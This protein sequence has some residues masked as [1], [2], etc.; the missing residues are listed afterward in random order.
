VGSGHI[1]E[2]EAAA[3][4]KQRLLAEIAKDK[5]ERRARC[6]IRPGAFVLGRG[7]SPSTTTITTLTIMRAMLAHCRH[8]CRL[9]CV[10]SVNLF[11][12][13]YR[14]AWCR[15]GLPPEPVK[16]VAASGVAAP[17]SNEAQLA[18]AIETLS[19][20]KVWSHVLAAVLVLP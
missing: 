3:K 9:D 18:K 7:P 12:L 19:Q 8:G 20:Y 2:K 4:E 5:A 10:F 17:L 16:P 14:D 15:M 11:C 13:L 1:Q 6:W